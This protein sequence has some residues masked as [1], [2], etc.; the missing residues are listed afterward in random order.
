MHLN[1]EFMLRISMRDRSHGH[2]SAFP[3]Q[4]LL[5]V[6]F[7]WKLLVITDSV[8]IQCSEFYKNALAA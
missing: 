1:D 5:A 6:G 4:V 3:D 8:R 7:G 2:V